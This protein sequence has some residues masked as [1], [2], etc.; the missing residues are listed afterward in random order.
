[1]TLR[2][3]ILAGLACAMCATASYA[4][5]D[6][7]EQRLN[8]AKQQRISGDLSGAQR[9]VAAV[10]AADPGHFRANYQLGLIQLD[11]G[12]RKDGVATLRKTIEGL[13]GAPAPDPT[14]Y[15]T[16]GW[17]LLQSGQLYAA[18]K[19]FLQGYAERARL[20]PASRAKLLNNMGLLYRLMGR[21]DLSSRYVSEAAAGGNVPAQQTLARTQSAKR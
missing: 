6:A 13:K 18:E 15:N 2:L 1:M 12:R 11:Q 4:Q 9:S 21:N 7:Y 5:T 17:A 8:Q 14:I 10:L 3:A 16:L 20:T 19:P